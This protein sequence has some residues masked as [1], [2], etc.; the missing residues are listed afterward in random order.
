MARQSAGMV[1]V[2]VLVMLLLL[3][4]LAV[5]GITANN[6]GGQLLRNDQ[7]RQLTN[8]AAE[9]IINFLLS[10][11]DYFIHYRQYLDNAGQFSPQLP[12]YL[13]AES[14]L[15]SQINMNCIAEVRADGCSL[16]QSL[17]CPIYYYWQIQVKTMDQISKTTAQISQGVKFNYLP[18]YCFGGG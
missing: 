7:R 11:P 9:N 15:K 4:V 13:Q 6:I 2:L 3:E 12:D 14:I 1:L 17:A 16:D 5:A 10:N 8:Q 18:G